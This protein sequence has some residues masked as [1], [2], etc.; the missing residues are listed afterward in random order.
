VIIHADYSHSLIG[1]L[2]ISLFAGILAGLYWN[3]KSG[4]IIGSVAFSHWLLDLIVHH[5]DIPFLPGNLGELPLLGLGLWSVPTVSMAF[6]GLLIIVGSFLY[7][8][9]AIKS[10]GPH[11]R[12]IGAL[13]RST[14]MLFLVCSLLSRMF[15]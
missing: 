13:M 15:S 6:E 10:A 3:K 1:A 7:F 14:M 9:Y 4:I 8:R 5:P 12:G 2:L 11:R